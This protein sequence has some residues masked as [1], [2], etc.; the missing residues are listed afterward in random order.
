MGAKSTFSS[1][2][3]EGFSFCAI[4]AFVCEEEWEKE[5][6]CVV[7]KDEKDWWREINKTSNPF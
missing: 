6:M 7:T 1:S 3:A 2:H 5:I 4:C